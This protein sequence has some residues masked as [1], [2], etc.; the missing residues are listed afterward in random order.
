MRTWLS[1]LLLLMSVGCTTDL[2]EPPPYVGPD[3]DWEW[4]RPP[5]GSTYAVW[6]WGE[7][8]WVGDSSG[9][10]HHRRDGVWRRVS[11]PIPGP[12][13]DLHGFGPDDIF[14]IG[15]A[16]R[17]A[18][19]DGEGWTEAP[20]PAV[21]SLSALWGPARDHL[22]A[23][24][25]DGVI[26]RFD[27]TR[28]TREGTPTDAHLNAVHGLPDGTVHALAWD[29]T[30]LR[31]D[32]AGWAEVSGPGGYTWADLWVVSA[33]EIHVVG[34]RQVQGPFGPLTQGRIARFDGS[35]WS[36]LDE[37]FSR[38]D[39][40]VG[41]DDGSLLAV[42]ISQARRWDGTAWT[43]AQFPG[44]AYLVDVVAVGNTWIS[45][46]HTGRVHRGDGD[47][48]ED[49]ESG[50]GGYLQG[51]CKAGDTWYASGG[52]GK[53][54]RRDGDD[55][56]PIPTGSDR[57]LQEAWGAAA[58]DLHVL[59]SGGA[60]LHYDG[61]QW[62]EQVPALPVPLVAIHGRSALDIVVVGDEGTVLRFDGTDWNPMSSPVDGRLDD[63]WV[64]PDGM[65]WVVDRATASVHRH[66]GVE[67]E[68]W[69]FGIA[70]RIQ[71]VGGLAA[72]D[73]YAVS[74][75]TLMRFDGTGWAPVEWGGNG[76]QFSDLAAAGDHLV[77]LA[78][79]RRALR[80]FDGQWTVQQ[81]PGS[82]FGALAVGVDDE[83]HAFAT[84]SDGILGFSPPP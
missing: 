26:L 23:V 10:I 48:W 79:G 46:G 7:E 30:L 4:S 35:A 39:A 45:L 16:G 68:T 83:G 11:L 52:Q 20:A 15:L 67:W 8:I 76:L 36:S 6:A 66:D 3:V 62:T 12:V 33:T 2:V 32:E 57:Y 38:L 25:A 43:S 65:V 42:G 70:R 22:F 18:H 37:P 27:G 41:T 84:A 21:R 80:W 53:V 69:N 56:I 75:S 78:S 17:I 60:I 71:H 28:W 1:L 61:S 54:L 9:G 50:I 24:G 29:G 63:V 44:S 47:T 51:I 19:F 64:A 5:A 72:D 82:A 73:V 40:I 59:G 13:R 55:W 31:R 74:Q 58:D 77:V 14:A 49:L 81:M 34:D